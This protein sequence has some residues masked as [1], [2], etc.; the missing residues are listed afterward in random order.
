MTIRMIAQA[1]LKDLR[2][3]APAPV[4]GG[5]FVMVPREADSGMSG[6]AV[7]RAELFWAQ[8]PIN[9]KWTALQTHEKALVCHLLA[10]AASP[11][12]P[13]PSLPDPVETG[14]FDRCPS[15]SPEQREVVEAMRQ[16]AIVVFQSEVRKLAQDEA[17][18]IAA[19][20]AFIRGMDEAKAAH[21]AALYPDRG[22]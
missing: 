9:R 4:D 11:S 22:E 5:E 7:E 20:E 19:T 17:A 13:S 18:F 15:P 16:A 2:F 12:R 8:L 21:L 14:L 6:D 3:D 10:L 1:S